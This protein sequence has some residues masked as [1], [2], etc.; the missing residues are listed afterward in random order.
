MLKHGIMKQIL[1]AGVLAIA[2]AW[3]GSLGLEAS[4][5]PSP[6]IDYGKDIKPILAKHCVEC[7]GA[8]KQRGDLR[9]DTLDP[10]FGGPSAETWHDV[11]DKVS[12]GGM[13]PEDEPAMEAASRR[14]LLDWVRNNL[15]RVARERKGISNQAVLRR[16]TRY[17]YNNTLHDLLGIDLD[18]AKAL[19]PESLS[20]DGFQNNGLAMGMSPLQLEYYLEAAHLAMSKAIVEGP[21]PK[22]HTY[23]F[24]QTTFGKA[25]TKGKA[26]AAKSN[27]GPIP[28]FI[29]G[30]KNSRVPDGRGLLYWM[31][32]FPREGDFQ[33]RVNAGSVAAKGLGVPRMRIGMATGFGLKGTIKILEEVDVT[34]SESDKQVYTFRGRMENWPLPSA[35]SKY[36][37]ITIIIFNGYMDTDKLTNSKLRKMAS[38]VSPDPS[39]LVVES[40]EFTAPFYKSWPPA[41]H[42]RLLPPSRESEPRWAEQAIASFM[43]KAYRRPVT[44]SD[45]D[46]VMTFYNQVRLASSSFEDAMRK[47]LAMVLISPEFLYLV[48][49][50]DGDQGRPLT[51]YELASRLSYFLWSTM[52]DEKLLALAGSGRLKDPSAMASQIRAMIADPRSD[53]FVQN[54]TD[55]WL[56][57]SGLNS[58]AI[59]P[60]Y[61]PDFDERLKPMMRQETEAFFAEVLRKDLS[62]LN[63]IDS[64]FAMVNRPLARH[65]GLASPQGQFFERVALKPAD[66]RGGLLTQGSFLM[67][68]S[69]GED[70]QPINRAVW[71]LERL[72]DD[73]PPPPPPGVP[74]LDSE[75]S[76]DFASLPIKKQLEMHRNREACNDCHRGIDPWGLAF[77]SFDAVGLKRTSTL[78]KIGRKTLKAPVDD[79]AKL[80]N[81]K[82]V[83]GA[84]GLQAYLLKYDGD[85]FAR[86][87][88]SKLLTYAVGRSLVLEDRPVL[89][90][91]VKDFKKNDYR[92][93]DLIVAIAQSEAFQNK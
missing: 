31:G 53:R 28:A 66:G 32:E 35:K 74:G 29:I 13:P 64:D 71:L 44:K 86:A 33:I 50:S 4:P 47:S 67:I 80:P 36:P 27:Q 14:K 9:L 85:R 55:Q 83:K 24:E 69:N 56:G 54:F 90:A 30:G 62:A 88:V 34:N 8:D 60:E 40:V 18:F 20:S 7:H 59:N 79:Q 17:E 70:S 1:G 26:T 10:A 65:Y 61:Y 11:L 25:S 2:A 12:V 16:L 46:L 41:H 57:L 63:F 78:R 22:K 37:G 21:A 39:E 19:P 52:P 73:P 15:D 45:V 92:L 84:Q 93:S 72:L 81:G 87:L 77:E 75:S 82:V 3:M 6:Q 42:T 89:E 49:P 91:L 58:V 76:K 68:N 5:K 38:R 51:Q 23:R 43:A 48:Q